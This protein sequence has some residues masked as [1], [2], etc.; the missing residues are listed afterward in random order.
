A[1]VE[2]VG[3]RRDRQPAD[4]FRLR[5]ESVGLVADDDRLVALQLRLEAVRLRDAL[6]DRVIRAS[7]VRRGDAF[8]RL[9]RLLERAEVVG[10]RAPA[11]I[12]D[13][14]RLGGGGLELAG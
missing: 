12:R 3:A 8:T 1:A 14:D 4:R 6:L 2:A 10:R 5:L 9:A 11:E 7:E 13:L